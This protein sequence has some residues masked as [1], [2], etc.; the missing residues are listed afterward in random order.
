MSRDGSKPLRHGVQ[1]CMLAFLLAL[2]AASAKSGPLR[3]LLQQRRAQQL[4]SEPG[5]E[6]GAAATL[7]AGIKLRRNLAY[8]QDKRQQLD[9]YLPEHPDSAPILFMV[10]GGGWRAGSKAARS[11]VE[12]KV[13]RWVPRGFI[14]VSADYRMLPGTDPLHQAEDVAHAL[15]YVQ[16][17]ALSWGGDPRKI[18]VLGHSAG[19]HLVALLAADPDKARQFGVR[20]WLGTVSLDSAALDVEQVMHRRHL[21][22]YDHAFGSSPDYWRVVSPIGNLQGGGMPMLLVCSTQRTDGSCREAHQ[23]VDK[24]RS[25]GRSASVLEQNLSHLEINRDL[26]LPGA[27]TSGVEAFLRSLDADMARRLL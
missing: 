16:D 9:I 15:A 5:E 4:E 20:P 10:H 26:G 1:C 23:F 19:A 24:A 11:V 14:L 27:Y 21:P 13:A 2:L 12:N 6:G 3:D 7:P 25:L 8:G 18:T 17:N 22:L